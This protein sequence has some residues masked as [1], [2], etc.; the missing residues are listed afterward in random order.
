MRWGAVAALVLSLGLV[1]AT[2]AKT[3]DAAAVRVLVASQ[4]GGSEDGSGKRFRPYL[5]FDSDEELE[6]I[7]V[8]LSAFHCIPVLNTKRI[9]SN[10]SRSGTRGR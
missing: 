10:A 4:F 1:L 8:A 9:A 5:F 2:G 7:P 6:Q 3:S